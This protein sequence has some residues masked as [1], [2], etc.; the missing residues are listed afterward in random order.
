MAT[1]IKFLKNTFPGV[2]GLVVF[3]AGMFACDHINEVHNDMC[4][5][6]VRRFCEYIG[7]E[8][9]ILRLIVTACGIT[10]A[11]SLAKAVAWW[12]SESAAKRL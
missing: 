1:A 12:D 3:L 6:D 11:Y 5:D 4:A 2:V 10:L 9:F 7:T 8:I